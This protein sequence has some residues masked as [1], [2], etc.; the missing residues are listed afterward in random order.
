M[1]LC[2]GV[3]R[4]QSDDTVA[5]TVNGTA[6]RLPEVDEAATLTIFAG[7]N[8]AIALRKSP[9]EYFISRKVLE[10]MCDSNLAS[11]AITTL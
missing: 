7:N 3:V 4:L 5:A 10:F 1:F 8:K 9:L 6:L 2:I 11:L